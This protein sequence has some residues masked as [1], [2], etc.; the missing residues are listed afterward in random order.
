MIATI[1]MVGGVVVALLGAGL[2]AAASRSK[3]AEGGPLVRQDFAMVVLVIG[4][5]ALIFGTGLLFFRL[6]VPT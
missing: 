2:A 3:A 1:L 5:V 4:I 6:T